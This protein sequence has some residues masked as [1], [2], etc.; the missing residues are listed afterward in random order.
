MRMPIIRNKSVILQIQATAL[1]AP[2]LKRLSS[3][4]IATMLTV[5]YFA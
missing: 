4:I 2:L 1:K 5:T 3:K